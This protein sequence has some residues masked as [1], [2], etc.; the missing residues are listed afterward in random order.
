MV[1][2]LDVGVLERE[3]VVWACGLIQL[4]VFIPIGVCDLRLQPYLMDVLR[5]DMS[6]MFSVTFLCLL[7][8]SI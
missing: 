8:L 5:D 7:S 2:D 3:N 1:F 4:K 6:L